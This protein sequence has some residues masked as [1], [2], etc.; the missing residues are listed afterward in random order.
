MGA[1]HELTTSASLL[2]CLAYAMSQLDWAVVA[3]YTATGQG[4]SVWG[5]EALVGLDIALDGTLGNTPC[6]KVET[7]PLGE[8]E[9][10]CIYKAYQSLHH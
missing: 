7:E 5:R 4:C 8:S 2:T 3:C 9:K 10:G 1:T 6:R